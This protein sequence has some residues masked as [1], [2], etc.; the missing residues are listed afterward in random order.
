MKSLIAIV[1]SFGACVGLASEPAVKALVT[2]DLTQ[3]LRRIKPMQ[4]VNNGPSVDKPGADQVRSNADTYRAARFPYART[5]DSV[6]CVSS[7][8]SSGHAVDINVIFPDFD[9]DEADPR[10]YDFVFTDHYLDAIVRT[11]TKVFFRLG[12]SIEH[13]P[14]KYGIKPP[15]DYAKWAR[16]CEHVVRHYNE[17]WAWGLDDDPTT[18]NI[19]WSNQFNIVYWEIWNEPDLD[20]RITELPKNPR[21]WGGTATNYFQLYEISAKH[22]RK[23]FPQIKIGGPALCGNEDWA[24]LFLDYCRDCKAPL[25]F[26]SFHAYSRTPERIAEMCHRM[27]RYLDECGFDKTET[28]L[29][30]WNY[31]KGWC[32]DWVYSLRVESGDLGLKGAAYVAA[33]MTLCQDT[34]LDMLMFYDARL[35]TPMN[36]LFDSVTFWPK[37]GYYPFY[38]WSKL[39]D[40]GTQVACTVVEG[41]GRKSDA[42]TGFV[43][44]KD[45][46]VAGQFYAVAARDADG[47]GAVLITR[48]SDD[49]N[50]SE[51]G[52]VTLIVPGVD[53]SRARCLLTDL[54]RTCTDVPVMPAPDGA[55]LIRLQPNGFALVE[56]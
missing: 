42:N 55:V 16:I 50:S 15:E 12:Q 46:A 1:L 21:T 17:G 18:V 47:H 43:E 41:R 10:S 9:A 14:K 37:K 32:D 8:A 2:V 54:A 38:L 28:I 11:G 36:N 31:V 34:P 27:R 56:Y 5:H 4:A 44:R 3:E 6:N 22:L 25:D 30:E 52:T 13:G 23:V 19:A 33:T 40:Y 29:N 7:T 49:D 35:N 24:K 53:L 45:S 51:T 39:A 20:T 26:F 48:Y